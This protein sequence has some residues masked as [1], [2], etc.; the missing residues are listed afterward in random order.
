MKYGIGIWTTQERLLPLAE[1]LWHEGKISFIEAVLIPDGDTLFYPESFR[2][3]PI[4]QTAHF[5]HDFWGVNLA[6][7]SQKERNIKLLQDAKVMEPMFEDIMT[8]HLGTLPTPEGYDEAFKRATDMVLTYYGKDAVIENLPKIGF[9]NKR[10]FCI[11]YDPDE[12]A[13]LPF[14]LCLDI[15]H[16]G[17]YAE[18]EKLMLEPLI[19]RFLSLKP[20]HYHGT[21]VAYKKFLPKDVSVVIETARTLH[22]SLKENEKDLRLWNL[23]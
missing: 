6:D 10:L 11:G 23:I 22:K 5:P 7:E 21:D 17:Q 13:D 19:Q 16:A 15:D 14:R 3:C 2:R 18:Q 9:D 20:V 4:P 1:E 8:I 12:F